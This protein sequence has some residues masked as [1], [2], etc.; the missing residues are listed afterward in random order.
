MAKAQKANEKTGVFPKV[1]MCAIA[2]A[3]FMDSFCMQIIVPNLPFA[4]KKWFPSVG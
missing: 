3:S 2:A 1:A 4:V